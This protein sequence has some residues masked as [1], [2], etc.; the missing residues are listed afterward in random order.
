MIDGPALTGVAGGDKPLCQM[1]KFGVNRPAIVQGSSGN[2][3]G[4]AGIDGEFRRAT[5]GVF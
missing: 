1:A 2:F 5:I 4:R 3:V